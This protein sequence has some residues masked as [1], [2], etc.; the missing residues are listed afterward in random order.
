VVD[1]AVCERE[2][3]R[4]YLTIDRGVSFS[5]AMYSDVGGWSGLPSHCVREHT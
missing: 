3:A 2:T 4:N 1:A 5:D